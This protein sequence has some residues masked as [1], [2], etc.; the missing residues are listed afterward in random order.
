MMTGASIALATWPGG[1]W[2]A[3]V[4]VPRTRAPPYSCS[5]SGGR[6]FIRDVGASALCIDHGHEEIWKA[7]SAACCMIFSTSY[8]TAVWSRLP[9]MMPPYVL[10]IRN[11]GVKPAVFHYPA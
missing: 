9:I 5:G 8:Q 2:S 7:G 10:Y 1:A 4:W 11:T 3:I 6:S